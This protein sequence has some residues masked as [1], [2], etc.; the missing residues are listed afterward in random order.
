MSEPGK[1]SCQEAFEK[2]DDFLCRELTPEDIQRLESHLC[3]CFHCAEA[4]KAEGRLHECIK[5]KIEKIAMPP[6]LAQRVRAAL[7]SCDE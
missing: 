4:F 2:L 7:D 3:E 5:R 6:D 1:C